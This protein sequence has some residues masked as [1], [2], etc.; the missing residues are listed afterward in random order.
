ME[1]ILYTQYENWNDAK[2]CA[3]DG[4]MPFGYAYI[5]DEKGLAPFKVF[6]REDQDVAFAKALVDYAEFIDGKEQ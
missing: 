3:I 4:S 1:W 5:T 6:L 2:R